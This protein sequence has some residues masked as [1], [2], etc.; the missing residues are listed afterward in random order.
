MDKIKL[1]PVHKTIVISEL[2][3]STKDYRMAFETSLNL[4]HTVLQKKV[5]FLQLFPYWKTLHKIQT[6]YDSERL[7]LRIEFANIYFQE[8]IKQ[9][10]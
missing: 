6:F 3:N 1:F 9:I 5:K 2:L 8:F 7:D 4:T 10:K